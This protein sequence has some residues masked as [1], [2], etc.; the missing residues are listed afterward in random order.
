MNA[1]EK[2]CDHPTSSASSICVLSKLKSMTALQ[3]LPVSFQN[4]LHPRHP[5]SMCLFSMRS[6]RF[7]FYLYT[8]LVYIFTSP[9]TKPACVKQVAEL[10]VWYGIAVLHLPKHKYIPNC[11]RW[12]SMCRSHLLHCHVHYEPCTLCGC[13]CYIGEHTSLSHDRATV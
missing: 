5:P 11:P 1:C 2:Y 9:I 10:R 6:N 3:L 7:L 4:W 8:Y 13:S 12:I